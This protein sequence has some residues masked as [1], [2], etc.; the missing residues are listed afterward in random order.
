MQATFRKLW[1]L[2]EAFVKARGD[3]IAFELVKCEFELCSGKGGLDTARVAVDG[4]P[5]TDWAFFVHPLACGHWVSTSRGPPADAID[6]HGEFR[7]TFGEPRLGATVH[8]AE[9]ARG[10]P[11]FVS[12]NV[13]SLL[14]DELR[15]AHERV[16]EQQLVP[17][18]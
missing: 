12:R 7:A 13:A 17:L 14:P 3:G 2:K 6:A 4:I 18:L 16:A 11:P 10:E 8:A 1:S 15:A 9:L 5:R